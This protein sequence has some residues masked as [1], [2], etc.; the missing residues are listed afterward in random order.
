[1]CKPK[2]HLSGRWEKGGGERNRTTDLWGKRKNPESVPFV[3]R[4][5]QISQIIERWFPFAGHTAA[6]DRYVHSF[7][8]E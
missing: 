4:V 7:F 3:Q 5:V 6:V 1:M 2:T 8:I